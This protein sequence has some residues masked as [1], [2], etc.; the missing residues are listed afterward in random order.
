MSSQLKRVGGMMFFQKDIANL[1]S[2]IGEMV[3][4]KVIIKGSLG[5]SKTFEK[6]AIIE[7]TYPELFTVR[8]Q[9]NERN[10]AYSYKDI[11]TKTVQLDVFDGENYN[12][13]IPPTANAK[14]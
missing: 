5:R 13:L 14:L 8:Y 1:K 4:K 7:N 2:D 10:T 6:E 9:G 3:G 12:P 11:L